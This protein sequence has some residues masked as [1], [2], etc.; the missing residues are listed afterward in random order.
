[1]YIDELQKTTID[2][3]RGMY[4][5]GMADSCPI[6]HA[7]CAENIQFN[8][9]QLAQRNGTK[10]SLQTSWPIKRMFLATFNDANI[11]PITVDYNGNIYQGTNSIPIFSSSAIDYQFLNLFNKLYILPL[12]PSYPPPNLQVWDGI[13]P[14]RPACGVSPASSFI[15]SNGSGDATG[16]LDIGVHQF[17]V[18]FVTNTGFITPPGPIIGGTFTPVNYTAL[19]QTQVILTDIPLGPTGTVARWIL[20]TRANET[21][22]FFAPNGYIAD[23]ISTS[24]TLDFFDSSLSVNADYL[25]NLL[26]SLL[27]G[28]SYGALQKYHGRL[29]AVTGDL[30]RVSRSGDPESFDNTVGY[31]QIPAERDGNITR[32]CGILNDVLYLS[33]AV[34]IFAVQDNGSDPSTWPIMV[35]DSSVGSYQ[36]ALGSITGSQS[37]LPVMNGLLLGSREGLFLFNGS[38][39]RP[40]L[41]WKIDDIWGTITHGSEGLITVTIDVFNEI[42]Y[43]LLP[44]NGSTTPNLLLSGDYSEGLDA[45]NI[46]WAQHFFPWSP[47]FISMM[48]FQDVDGAS[49]YDYYLRLGTTSG[50]YKLEPSQSTDSGQNIEGYWTSALLGG[51]V[52]SVFRLL[53]FRGRGI[54]SLFINLFP[55]DMQGAVTPPSIV[56]SSL[57][58]QDFDRQINFMGEKMSVKFGSTKF[59]RIDRL[60]VFSR[61]LFNGRPQ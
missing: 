7:I 11:I 39:V 8:K 49:D 59:F 60:D 24:V 18:S 56:L 34:G 31:I 23:N 20:V 48:N 13:N 4:K 45:E 36:D 57:P 17:A 55:E 61:K 15:A 53:R 52:I 10:I 47:S 9:G 1:M 58:G 38:V 21:L 40:Q 16:G 51:G 29:I 50:I 28:N 6:D 46:K 41:S 5:R 22:F 42:I 35:I 14:V 43:V 12:S 27:G 19:G 2:T 37:P 54:D 44:T 33:K 26:P 25:F 3:F 30:V 32:S